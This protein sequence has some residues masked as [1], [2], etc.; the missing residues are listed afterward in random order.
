MIVQSVFYTTSTLPL[1]QEDERDWLPF[2]LPEEV[3]QTAE[4][5]SIQRHDTRWMTEHI[6]STIL[7]NKNA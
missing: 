4:E 3:S 2:Q 7:A 5:D 6:K 1:H